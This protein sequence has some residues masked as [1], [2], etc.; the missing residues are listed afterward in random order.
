MLG[1]H[2]KAWLGNSALPRTHGLCQDSVSCR[3]LD[4][5]LRSLLAVGH[6]HVGVSIGQ[7]MAWQP[8]S[9]KPARERESLPEVMIGYQQATQREG[10]LSAWIPR[11]RDRGV[12]LIVC[13]LQPHRRNLLSLP[14]KDPS[15]TW[16]SFLWLAHLFVLATPKWVSSPS[17]PLSSELALLCISKWGY[18]QRYWYTLSFSISDWNSVQASGW[19]WPGWSGTPW[20]HMHWETHSSS[21]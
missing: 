7:L 21:Y 5:G 17:Q 13:L 3:L 4:K 11:G 6:F 18:T 2:L 12:H 1:S 20:E 10:V 19:N 14:Q 8:A 16:K 15:N 9:S